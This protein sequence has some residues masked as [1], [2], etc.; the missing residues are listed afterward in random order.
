M[1][2]LERWPP[3]Y[4]A[5]EL[6]EQIRRLVRTGTLA[7]RFFAS[8]P[9]L[10]LCQGDIFR[11]RSPLPAIADDGEPAIYGDIEYWMA[12]GNTCDFTRD[13]DKVRWT[14]LV[15]IEDL[16]TEDNVSQDDLQRLRLYQPYR[17]FYIPPWTEELQGRIIQAD[18]TR[19]VTVHKKAVL[20]VAQLQARLSRYGWVLFHSC[21]IRFL[22]RD[23]GRYAP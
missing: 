4:D 1:V 23:D 17:S 20:E 15:P 16:G 18:F 2:A 19:P 21:L 13:L 12:I 3:V 22:A 5:A 14:Q 6:Q 9:D 11:M 8:T 10:P 7:A